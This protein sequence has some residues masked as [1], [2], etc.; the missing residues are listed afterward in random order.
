VVPFI[1]P[2]F[3]MFPSWQLRQKMTT[4]VGSCAPSA[5]TAAWFAGSVTVYLFWPSPLKLKV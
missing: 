1:M 4:E 5:V 3:A 2:G